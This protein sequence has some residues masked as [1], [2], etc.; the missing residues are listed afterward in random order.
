ML[1]MLLAITAVCCAGLAVGAELHVAPGGSDRNPGTAD[2]PLATLSR[3]RDLARAAKTRQPGPLTVLLRSGVYYL[4]E[5]LVFT[6]DDS[7][8]K[9]A[10]LVFAAA[11]GETPVISGGRKLDLAWKAGAEGVM[12]AATPPGLTIDQL[13]VNGK[14][15]CMARFPNRIAGKNVF[16]RWDLSHGGRAEPSEDA[17]ARDRIARWK[18]PAGGYVHAMHPALWGDM[19]WLIKGRK[20]DGSLDLEGGWQNNRPGPMHGKF[21]FAENI[22]EE[23]DA[24]GEWFH[25]AKAN[26]LYFIPEPGT[27]LKTATVE[28]VRLAHLIEFK[29]SKEK[30]VQFVE[31]RGLTFRHAARTFMDNK[32]PLLRSDWTVYRGGAV[33]Y[34]GAADCTVADCAFDQVG[35]NT[36]F[37][38]NWNRRIVVRGCLIQDSGANGV[39]FV[40]DPKAVRN[41]LFRYGAQDYA[42]LDRTPGPQTDN[43]PADCVVEDCLITRTG[44]DEKQTAPVQISMA[45]GITVRHCSIYDVP[46]AG[47]NISEGTWGGHLIE[48][49]DVFNTVLETGDHGSFNSWGRDRYWHPDIGV[50]NKQVAADPKL[51]LLDVVKPIVMRNNRWRCDHGWDV[52]LDDGSTNYEIYNNLLLH[53]GLKL[54]EGFFRKVYN[55]ITV[56]N[57]LH[58]HCWYDQCQGEVTNNIFMGAYQPAGGMPKGKWGKEVDRNLF[59]TSEGDRTRFAGNGCD[60]NSVVGD[61]QFIDPAK[62]DYRV[63]ETSPALKLGFKNFPMDQVGVQKPE[64]KKIAK[65]PE[66]PGT[67]V[68]PVAGPAPQKSRTTACWLQ[69]SVKAL[70]GEEFS[71]FGVSR[72]AGGL[73]LVTVPAGSA[74]ARAGLRKDDLLM[75]VNRKALKQP[76]DLAKAMNDAGGQP[77]EVE[78]IRNQQPQKLKVDAYPFVVAEASAEGTFKTLPLADAAVVVRFQA[79]KSTPDTKNEPL[80]TLQD[81]KLAANYGPV[82]GNGTPVGLFK[83]DLGKAQELLEINTWSYSEGLRGPQHFVLYG[84]AADADPGWNVGDPKGFTPIAEVNTR[85]VPAGKFNATSVRHSKG[86]SLGSFRWLIWATYPLNAIGEHTAFQELQAKAVKK[87]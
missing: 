46:R 43:Y 67:Q 47:I 25:D 58:P 54:R 78:F 17:M 18:D 19:H 56:G 81:G 82:F 41:P 8:A 33:V 51:P 74:A 64:L 27:D 57:S 84:S 80:A 39:A 14:R 1:L 49:C 30:P 66:L 6:A 75:S 60:A 50:G 20:P 38:S 15:Q 31:L 45:Q 3:A 12:E 10:P 36:I 71:A 34:D 44:R 76:G 55:N 53:G 9:D 24:P 63:K 28:V 69:A 2:Q 35:G 29:G 5:T 4:P 86:A 77:L 42:K 73:Q 23:L 87:D 16:D 52:D 11:P 62:G 72:D 70:E 26:V 40:G 37:V 13:W 79:I 83:I 65:T 22:R 32:E 68:A 48:F 7:G 85:D 59:T 21:R 61:A